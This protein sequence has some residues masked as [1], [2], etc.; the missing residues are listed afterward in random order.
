MVVAADF[1]RG[2]RAGRIIFAR[3]M[4][5]RM[6]AAINRLLRHVD[7]YYANDAQRRERR[8][9]HEARR[10]IATECVAEG[11]DG[12]PAKGRFATV[13][14]YMQY[15]L[16]LREL[17][18]TYG[19]QFIDIV[20][21]INLVGEKDS[22]AESSIKEVRRWQQH[23]HKNEKLNKGS[24][25][26]LLVL[27]A[28]KETLYAFAYLLP[29]L[30]P[31]WFGS[32]ADVLRGGIRLQKDL[33]DALRGR[34]I[35]SPF[36]RTG[37]CGT[38]EQLLREAGGLQKELGVLAKNVERR[39]P[40]CEKLWDGLNKDA[41]HLENFRWHRNLKDAQ[42]LQEYIEGGRDEGAISNHVTKIVQAGKEV[43][44]RM[45]KT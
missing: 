42:G 44:P 28:R 8:L 45:P 31:H 14:R 41:S 1:L 30:P 15:V 38:L 9:R 18:S 11:A 36:C 5:K 17:L 2:Y 7:P 16:T 40:D 24:E 4:Q 29:V 34:S 12:W 32:A 43:R 20:E 37:K 6:A 19:Q 21:R 39:H 35:G 33:R 23:L 25:L 3:G 22:A 10:G 27:L 13:N 26:E